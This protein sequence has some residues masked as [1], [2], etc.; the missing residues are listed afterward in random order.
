MAEYADIIL[1]APTFLE[2][3]GYD[4]SPP[5]S[6]FA[7]AKIKQPVVEPLHDTRSITDIIFEIAGKLGGTVARSF[8]NIGNDAE[9]FVKYRTEALVAWSEFQEKGVWLGQPY[10]YRRY[11]RIFNTPSRK[12]EFYSGN[13]QAALDK[14]VYG[15]GRMAFLPHYEEAPFFGDEPGYPLLLSTYQPLLNIENGNQNYPWA[16]EIYLVMHGWGWTNFAEINSET[17]HELGIRDRE[18]VWVESPFGRIKV[19]ARVIQGIH[20]HVVSIASGQGHYAGGKWQKD[21]GVNP[22]DITGVAYDKLSGQSSFFN[23]RVKVYK[24]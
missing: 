12:F 16:Q 22:N 11:D 5:G 23:T 20:P 24:A 10:Q 18:E 7:E 2:E 8:E 15:G 17:A 3:W 4:H 14:T 6:G 1:P 21:I 9:G 19:R 13:L